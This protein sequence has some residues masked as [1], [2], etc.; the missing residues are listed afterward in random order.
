VRPQALSAVINA[1]C[2]LKY[3]SYCDLEMI[4]SCGRV[5]SALEDAGVIA[6]QASAATLEWLDTAN[7][8]IGSL[9]NRP[10]APIVV[11]SDDLMPDSERLGWATRL[12]LQKWADFL[13]R[14]TQCNLASLEPLV[15]KGRPKS[16]LVFHV[17]PA[18][19]SRRNSS[20]AGVAEFWGRV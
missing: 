18:E 20:I 17:P 5:R 14:L 12:G 19:I 9:V 2:V 11:S 8:F 16:R 13:N 7:Y 6:R 3:P 10:D 4:A 1:S 15:A